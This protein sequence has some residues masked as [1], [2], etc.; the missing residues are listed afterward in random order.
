MIVE[1]FSASD[2]YSFHYRCFPASG[3]TRGQVVYLHGIQSHGGWYESSCRF[4][5]ENGFEVFFLD[6]R[7]SG[8]NRE[9]RGD[10]PNYHRLV[11]D[12]REFI[13]AKCASR[14][15]LIG[16][17][18]GGKLACAVERLA[19][20]TTSGLLLLTPGI[21]PQ[22]RP[23]LRT[24]LAIAWS[25]LFRPS[26]SFAIPLDDPQLF[27]ANPQRQRYIQEDALSL[28]EA[29]ARFLVESV[30][31]DFLMRRTPPTLRVPILLMLAGKDRIIDNAKT[32]D[33]L[34]RC[35]TTEKQIITYAEAHHTL[36]FESNPQPV[37][38]DMLTWMVSRSELAGRAERS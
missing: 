38:E 4:F 35:A 3:P 9:A 22:V 18:W 8:L 24:R 36:E 27:T 32:Q 10:T 11:S 6:R 23:P 33:W 12:V 1:T 20:Q 28:R 13:A 25:R 5:A 21:C 29:T 30:R 2:G 16:V 14:P 26:R 19:P 31:L 37:F 7:G 15:L 34:Q 17:S